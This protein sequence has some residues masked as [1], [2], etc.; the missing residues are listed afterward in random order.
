MIDELSP[1]VN[2]KDHKG[3][4]PLMNAAFNNQIRICKLLISNEADVNIKNNLNMQAIDLAQSVETK[5]CLKE[6]MRK[7][8]LFNFEQMLELELSM[9]D[10]TSF[11]DGSTTLLNSHRTEENE[12]GN[13]G[14]FQ[15]MSRPAKL[16]RFKK[17]KA[18]ICSRPEGLS[19]SPLHSLAGTKKS[20]SAMKRKATLRKSTHLLQI[21]KRMLRY[22][23]KGTKKL[24]MGRRCLSPGLDFSKA[25][26]MLLPID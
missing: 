20:L 5:E 18:K 23:K 1:N 13:R 10:S 7:A 26:Y 9:K 25:H 17:S 11:L 16:S 4:T 12:V 19:R 22:E 2:S 24:N 14:I 15:K 21:K 8:N 6:E 3:W